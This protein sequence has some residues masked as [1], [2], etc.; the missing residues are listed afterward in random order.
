MNVAHEGL[1]HGNDGES[2]G[3]RGDGT[4]DVYAVTT[5]CG[6]LVHIPFGAAPDYTLK[7]VDCL[8]CLGA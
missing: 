2:A 1:V 7:S 8:D 4:K 6:E 3:V 5:W